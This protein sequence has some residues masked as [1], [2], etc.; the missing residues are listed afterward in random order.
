VPVK[1]PFTLPPYP[2][3]LCLGK[4]EPPN[5]GSHLSHLLVRYV[6]S[7][8]R[9]SQRSWLFTALQKVVTLDHWICNM[10]ERDVSTTR[11]VSIYLSLYT[12]VLRESRISFL[13]ISDL[14]K[15]HKRWIACKIYHHLSG[16]ILLLVG[17]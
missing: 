5:S 10:R 7:F 15:R 4:G 17:S 9:D 14:N 16:H 3:V 8:A 13:F 6:A 1:G 11:Y 2:P 12:L